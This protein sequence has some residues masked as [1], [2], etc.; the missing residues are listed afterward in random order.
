MSGPSLHAAFAQAAAGYA[1]EILDAL[2]SDDH[3]ALARLAHRI[4]GGAAMY[5]HPEISAQAHLLE[6][7]L[8][9]AKAAIPVKDFPHFAESARELARLC[10]RAAQ[11]AS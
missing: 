11:R 1:A 10:Q 4:K 7:G 5:G 8:T 9:T 6:Q 2:R 3:D